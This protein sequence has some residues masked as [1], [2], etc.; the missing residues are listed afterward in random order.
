[1]SSSLFWKK[2]VELLLF[3]HFYYVVEFTGSKFFMLFPYY[4]FKI[5]I[6][7]LIPDISESYLPLHIKKNQSC[8]RCI[9]FFT[10]SRR[11]FWV[12]LAFNIML[13]VCTYIFVICI[14][15]HSDF[16]CLFHYIYCFPFFLLNFINRS[17]DKSLEIYF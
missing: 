11:K 3:T 1:M 4:S 14:V 16:Y 13:A 5:H 2:F 6:L 15:F 10:L 17:W 9:N 7:F 8:Y 12:F